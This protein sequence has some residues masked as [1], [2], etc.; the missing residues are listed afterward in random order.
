MPR[1]ISDSFSTERNR[2]DVSLVSGLAMLLFLMV[3]IA[4]ISW[5]NMKALQ[6]RLDSMVDNHLLKIRLVS[7]MRVAARE[8]TLILHKIISLPDAFDRDQEWMRFNAEASRFAEARL[9][10]IAMDLSD[11]ERNILSRQG[12][13]TGETVPVQDQ[14]VDL[15]MND[16]PR[17]ARM[18]LLEQAVPSQDR[19]LAEL[20]T[21]FAYQEQAATVAAQRARS[22]GASARHWMIALG[23]MIVAFSAAVATGIVR[24]NRQGR[25]ALRAEKEK[26]QVTLLSIGEAVVATDALGRIESLN[27]VAENLTGWTL[28][29]AQGMLFSDVFP[30]RHENAEKPIGDLLVRVLASSGVVTIDDLI[31][32]RKD[33]QEHA[34]E[35]TATPIYDEQ[36][37]VIGMVMVFRDVTEVRALS[38]ELGYQAQHDALTGLYNR[39]EFERRLQRALNQSRHAREDSVL[40][41]LDLDLFKVVNDTCGH[42]AGDE[43]L[44]QLSLILR[45]RIRRHDVLARLGGDEFGILLE[46]CD[47]AQ[48]EN[49]TQSIR[50]AISDFRFVWEDKSFELGVSVGVVPVQADSGTIYDVMR[51]ADLA[52]YAAKDRGRNQVCVYSADDL[53]MAQRQGELVWVQRIRQAMELNRFRLFAQ[54]I[55]PLGNGGN[56]PDQYM[57]EI[58]VR[59]EG[60]DGMVMP[61]A[62]MPAAERYHLAPTVDRW[63]IEAAARFIA[64][65]PG[66]L[67]ERFSSFSINLSG[68]SLG[69]PDML[70]FVGGVIE[71]TGVVANRLCFEV[72]ETAAITNLSAAR[73]FM[74]GLQQRGCRFA[75]DDFGS[76]LSSFAYL[77]TLPVDYLKI[78]GTFVRDIASDETDFAMVSSINQVSHIMGIRTIAEYV[79]NGDILDRVK[80]IG[81][82]FAQGVYISKPFACEPETLAHY[83]KGVEQAVSW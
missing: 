72:T 19:V 68:Q 45:E 50:R 14:V 63:V 17:E 4:A 49:V 10:L 82:D 37:N 39:Y 65:L 71:R 83:L 67:L 3:V 58:L 51:A 5:V 77:K 16:H 31:L 35:A 43:L 55:R 9:T 38:R 41:Y 26:A 74:E 2:A 73:V 36:K 79:E 56:G 66:N 8:R 76:G 42:V 54:P 6:E 52:C 32:Q 60:D 81:I 11:E 27:Q 40:C 61:S 47:L 24:G 69:D 28:A 1:R 44:K 29:Q 48:A 34:V 78:D 12:E 22:T 30:V 53:T 20:D 23:L 21:L 13:Y 33:G 62:F 18:L 25:A 7:T 70:E 80:L 64:S 46:A 57:A 15:A 59:I 75:L